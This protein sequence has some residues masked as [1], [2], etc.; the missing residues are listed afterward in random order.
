MQF[1]LET[2]I[3]SKENTK[4]SNKTQSERKH[5]KL[6]YYNQIYNPKMEILLNIV[7][8]IFFLHDF[9]SYHICALNLK[10]ISIFKI[11]LFFIYTFLNS[12]MTVAE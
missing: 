9:Y 10:K 3:I 1:V 2:K 7:F 8:L 4:F 11:A 12:T 5:F 6:H